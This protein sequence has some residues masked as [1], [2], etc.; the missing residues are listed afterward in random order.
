MQIISACKPAWH[1]FNEIGL[2]GTREQMSAVDAEWAASGHEAKPRSFR[3]VFGVNL[4]LP[5][6]E[7]VDQEART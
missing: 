4:E 1:F 7:W 2:Y 5:R 3:S 6:T